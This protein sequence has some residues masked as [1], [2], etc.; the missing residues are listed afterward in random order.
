[1]NLVTQ[2]DAKKAAEQGL[3]RAIEVSIDHHNAPSKMTSLELQVAIKEGKFDIVAAF[4]SL[5]Q[6]K[7][8]KGFDCKECVLG[9]RCA[10]QNT[11]WRSIK[12][13]F[14]TFKDNPSNANWDAFLAAEAKMVERLKV[15]LAKVEPEE[16]KKAGIK[17]V[18]CEYYTQ[19]PC[20]E[21]SQCSN[22]EPKKKQE[23][24][25]GDYGLSRI[26]SH[27]RLYV[28]DKGIRWANKS[29]LEDHDCIPG[30]NPILGN[31]FDDLASMSEPLEKNKKQVLTQ[32]Q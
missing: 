18:D 9:E 32:N 19:P 21:C 15:E 20:D 6:Y 27:P 22:F 13:A 29:Y 24:R 28:E 3:K 25:H 4:C 17:C 30:D 16:K 2:A 5:C 11:V 31:I 26:D 23:L 10:N 14:D 12:S 1:M 7:Y 8:I